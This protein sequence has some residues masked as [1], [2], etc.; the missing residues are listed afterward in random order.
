MTKGTRK[1]IFFTSITAIIGGALY[2]YLVYK[3]NKVN[4]KRADFI[5]DGFVYTV[6]TKAQAYPKKVGEFGGMILESYKQDKD[7]W[8]AKNSKAVEILLKKSDVKIV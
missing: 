1:V 7:Y 2:Y 8:L 3:K 6:G 5:T 4:G